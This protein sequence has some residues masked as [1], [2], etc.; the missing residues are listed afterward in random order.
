MTQGIV[1]PCLR[2]AWTFN[3]SWINAVPWY[4]FLRKTADVHE[5]PS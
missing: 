1:Q 2:A 3:A 5:I 4:T